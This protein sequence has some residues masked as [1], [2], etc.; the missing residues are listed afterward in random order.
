MKKRQNN[1][2][3]PPENCVECRKKYYKFSSVLW[4][5]K[6]KNIADIKW[7]DNGIVVIT[8]ILNILNGFRTQ[9][10]FILGKMSALETPTEEDVQIINEYKGEPETQKDFNIYLNDNALFKPESYIEED[11]AFVVIDDLGNTYKVDGESI[12]GKVKSVNGKEGDVI[13][14][15][16]DLENDLG[17]I[18]ESHSNNKNNPH[19]VTKAQIGLGN[20]DNTSDLNKPISTA[21]QT[22]LDKKLN[23]PTTN[24]TSD[25]VILADGTTE[26]KTNFGKVKTV[27]GNEPDEDGNIEVDLDFIPLKGTN[28]NDTIEGEFALGDSITYTMGSYSDITTPQY[29]RIAYG[30]VFN[31]EAGVSAFQMLPTGSV[32]TAS[33]ALGTTAVSV[34]RNGVDISYMRPDEAGKTEVVLSNNSLLAGVALDSQTNGF[35]GNQTMM[36]MYSNGKVNNFIRVSQSGIEHTGSYLSPNVFYNANQ[37]MPLI[38]DKSADALYNLFLGVDSNGNI[39]KFENAYNM[40]HKSFST[41]T[42]T[43]ALTLGQL[44]NGGQG[45]AGAMSV[46]LI[47]PDVVD[48]YYNTSEYI[49]LRGA[50]LLLNSTDMSISIC[51]LNRNVLTVIPNNQIINNSSTDLIFYYNFFN[52][53]QGEYLIKIT[54]GVKV[55]FTSLKLQVKRNLI[56]KDLSSLGWD[57]LYSDTSKIPSFDN[58]QGAVVAIQSRT[59]VNTENI[60]SSFKSSEIFE[61]GDDF[62]IEMSLNIS[63]INPGGS[64]TGLAVRI[65][66]GYSSTNNVL[67]PSTMLNFSFRSQSQGKID[68]FLNSVL[69]GNI[70][71]PTIMNLKIKKQG[72]LFT[73]SVDNYIFTSTF[74]NNSG[75]SLFFQAGG[76]VKGLN[77]SAIINRAYKIN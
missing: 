35:Q 72:N 75:Y 51:D 39:A 32:Q 45:S 6:F 1:S 7:K 49:V 23:K 40:L 68:I 57:L 60:L 38:P 61:E 66:L 34:L 22:E 24:N 9:I 17:Y 30:D 63:S 2:F 14:K 48:N 19:E 20:V 47:V 37:Q 26:L 31:P 59:D 13:L 76:N 8:K 5:E 52:Y 18:D 67:S 15:I 27:N 62:I 44:L 73:I 16:S 21:T 64:G 70:S 10:E 3:S 11:F 4:D 77:A 36:E 42:S 71:Y 65:G 69:K 50:N 41:M 46:N 12:S 54:S 33:S 28:G 43:Q 25:Y 56:N 55:Y 74:T 29:K 53:N 58:A